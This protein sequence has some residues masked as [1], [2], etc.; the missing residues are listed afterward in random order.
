[1][2]RRLSTFSLRGR[3]AHLLLVMLVIACQLTAPLVRPVSAARPPAIIV[4]IAAVIGVAKL[5]SNLLNDAIDNAGDEMRTTLQQLKRDIDDLIATLEDTYQENFNYSLGSIDDALS[6]KLLQ[7]EGMITTV[8]D[9]LI[10]DI[11]LIGDEVQEQ[12]INAQLAIHELVADVEIRLRNLIVV[13]GTTG[14]W[15]VD[16]TANNVILIA[17]IIMLGLGLLLFIFLMLRGSLPTGPPR[18]IGFTLIV[19]YLLLFGAMLV[20]P[21]RAYA[22]TFAGSDLATRLEQI[23]QEPRIF[24]IVPE[25]IIVGET[26]EVLVYGNTLEPAQGASISA[27]LNGVAAPLV[28]SDTRIAIDV[29]NLDLA[30]GPVR[31]AL[32][33][34]G[35][36][37]PNFLLHA[38]DPEQPAA[39]ADLV[40]T[41][42]RIDPPSPVQGGQTVATITIANQGQGASEPFNVLWLPDVAGPAG[43]SQRIREGLQ[44]GEE[45]E[46]VLPHGYALQG[47]FETSAI[48]DPPPGEVDESD[49]GNNLRTMRVTVSPAEAPC[50]AERQRLQ[51]LLAT[52]PNCSGIPPYKE[53]VIE[54]CLQRSLDWNAEHAQEVER[55]RNELDS[56]ACQP[57]GSD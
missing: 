20:P 49:E 21:A 5:A 12:I 10:E 53:Q 16:R 42:F 38:E 9:L 17:S 28:S 15:V 26:A 22:M 4:E 13:T 27:T 57:L 1:M 14:A 46:L 44:P 36:E 29:T 33:Y 30:P 6:F 31:F 51:S 25:T 40:V 2:K 32:L 43:P 48:V 56:A 45:T 54:A 24:R 18:T 11:E 47:A 52:K 55:L 41:G 35:Q 3:F 19:V 50:A 8:N 37:G 39:P 7:L 23:P 34:D